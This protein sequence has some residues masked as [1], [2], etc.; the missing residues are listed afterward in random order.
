MRRLPR[1]WVH[2]QGSIL[3]RKL[4]R[5]VADLADAQS[6]ASIK[7]VAAV[8]YVLEAFRKAETAAASAQAAVA[9]GAAGAAAEA[10]VAFR[11]EA[12]NC[13]K[14]VDAAAKQKEE[15]YRIR[16]EL[17][18]EIDSGNSRCSALKVVANELYDPADSQALAT[19]AGDAEACLAKCRLELL[20]VAN[21]W[22][23]GT[24]ALTASQGPHSLRRAGTMASIRAAKGGE[25]PTFKGSSLGRLPLGSAELWTSDHLSSRCRTM[26]ASSEK[27]KSFIA[28]KSS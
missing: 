24:L 14:V 27:K 7:G 12:S 9:A 20:T 2:L 4:K 28:Q 6:E 23:Q 25:R 5:C 19:A 15:A 1:W 18:S 11:A 26:D 8:A 17:L 22:D 10:I 16:A 21:S 3:Q 13:A